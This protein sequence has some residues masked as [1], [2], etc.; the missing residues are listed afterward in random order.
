MIRDQNIVAGG[1]EVIVH[2]KLPGRDILELR[3]RVRI[4]VL[5]ICEHPHLQ[6]GRNAT[7]KG[8]SCC[9]LGICI[10]ADRA[11]GAVGCD[12]KC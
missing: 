2:D 5:C 9:V 4:G 11:E 6:A 8:R 10:I 3:Q 12:V 7:R 1:V